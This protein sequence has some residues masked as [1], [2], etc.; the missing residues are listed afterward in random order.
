[1]D[2]LIISHNNT[3]LEVLAKIMNSYAT[4]YNCTV[5]YNSDYNS[6]D[7]YGESGHKNAIAHETS[8]ILNA[9]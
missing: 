8:Y 4:K 3:T 7:F 2:K 9:G 1:M 6:L 5:K